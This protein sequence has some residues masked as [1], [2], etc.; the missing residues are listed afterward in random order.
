MTGGREK[1]V[2]VQLDRYLMEAHGVTLGQLETRIRAAN[3]D[4]NAGTLEEDNRVY[5][6]RGLSRFRNPG[7]IDWRSPEYRRFQIVRPRKPPD[8]TL[9]QLKNV[10][11][12]NICVGPMFQI[13]D[14]FH[15]CLRFETRTRLDLE[16]ESYF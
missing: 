6:V 3:I 11:Q 4:I 13:L 2:R 5:L 16:P 15:I 8:S 1:E 10:Y 9:S 7:D 12:S 14:I